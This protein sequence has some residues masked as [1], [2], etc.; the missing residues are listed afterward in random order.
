MRALSFLLY[1]HPF[2]NDLSKQE[3]TVSLM[4]EIAKRQHISFIDFTD[5]P[6]FFCNHPD[7]FKDLIHLNIKGSEVFTPIVIHRII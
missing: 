7:L 6:L 1:S 4:E 2:L 5:D 3:Y